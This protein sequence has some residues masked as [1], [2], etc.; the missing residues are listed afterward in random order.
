[1]PVTNSDHL[2]GTLFMKVILL[3][4]IDG[5][6]KKHDVKDVSDGHAKNFL[7]PQRLAKIAT[8]DALQLLEKEKLSQ[9]AREQAVRKK[10]HVVL[11]QVRNTPIEIQAR[12]NDRGELFG[13]VSSAAIVDAFKG[14]GITIPKESVIIGEPIKHVGDHTVRINFGWG[15]ETKI[16]LAVTGQ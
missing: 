8:P 2:A 9:A 5:V 3:Q 10:M 1:L 15:I 6:G 13:A 12:A 16:T 4:N 7:L 11:E 14:K